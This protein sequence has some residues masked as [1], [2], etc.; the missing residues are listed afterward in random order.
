MKKDM[1]RLFCKLFGHSR[2]VWVSEWW[3]RG[4]FNTRVSCS[5]CEQV[6]HERDE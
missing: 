6:L 4:R 5:R 1:K 2:S 3:S